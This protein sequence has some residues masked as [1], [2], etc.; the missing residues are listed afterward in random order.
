MLRRLVI[1]AICALVLAAAPAVASAVAPQLSSLQAQ[2]LAR[3]AKGVPEV[4]VKNPLAQW[5][6]IFASDSAFW[7]CAL[8]A[9]SDGKAL[10]V[11]KVYDPQQRVWS[12]TIPRAGAAKQRLDEKQ[13]TAIAARDPKAADWIARYRDRGLPVRSIGTLDLGTW[14]IKWYSDATE[15]AQVGVS[16]ATG[17]ITYTRTGPQ[18]AWSMARGGQG[19]GRLINEPWAIGTLILLFVIVLI[20]WRRVRSL[21]TLDVLAIVSLAASLWCFN[22]GLVF[23]AVPLQYPPLIYLLVRLLLIGLGRMERPAFTT[24][25]PLWVMVALI[26]VLAVGRIGFNAYSSNVVDVGYAGVV[27]AD[28]ILDGR[29]PYGSFPVKSPTPCGTRYAD[30]TYSG[31]VQLNGRCETAIERGDTYGP[32]MYLSY[33]P[34]TAALGWSGRWDDLPA[35]HFTSGLF[36][37]LTAIGMAV[38]GW[39]LG[40]RRL[41]A[42]MALFWLALPWSAYTFMSDSNDSV[43]AAYLAWSAALLARPLGRGALLMLAALAKFAPLILIPLWLRL[44]RPPPTPLGEWPYGQA[45]L[46]PTRRQRLW[47]AVRP[48]PG[49]GWTLLGMLLVTV[50]LAGLLLVLDGSGALRTFWDR[51]FGWQLDRPSPFS[52]WDW[53]AYPGFPDLGV[54]QQILKVALVLGALLLFV[55]PRR[56]DAARAMALAGVLMIGFQIV[57][58]HWMY[59]YLPWVM[60]FVGMALLAPRS[61]FPR[62]RQTNAIDEALPRRERGSTPVAALSTGATSSRS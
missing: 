35:A 9:A 53:G 25:L 1:A 30:G 45:T 59:L 26:I 42:A 36:D 18:V 4:S 62:T 39:R 50:V 3:N 13:A 15:I 7:N 29:S 38:F 48:G 10:A 12:V 34:G 49:S 54:V 23:W 51:T 55:F 24:R 16:D 44:D 2:D 47:A 27:G 20:D 46:R 14:R 41:A 19:F 5:S 61:G 22:R 28:R 32:A 6:C 43:V 60:V 11:V 33:V 56:L 37:L 52:I 57:L 21:R 58:T 31:Y 8:N 40:G 17:A